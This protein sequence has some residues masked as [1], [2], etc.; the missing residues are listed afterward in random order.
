MGGALIAADFA[1]ALLHPDAARPLGLTD[2]MGRAAVRRFDV[3]RNNVTLGLIRVLEAGFPAVR[4]LV[5]EA[6]FAAMAGEFA[7]AHP[8]KTR[9]MMLSGDEFAGFI[10]QFPPAA[11]LGYLPCVARL[12]QALRLSYH[13]GDAAAMDPAILA[14]L[15]AQSLMQARFTCA[16]ALRLIT[17]PWPV[18]SIWR[19]SLHGGPAP[20]MARQEVIITRPAFD[21]V[22]QLLPMGAAQVIAQLQS[23]ARLGDALAG[24]GDDFDLGQTLSLLLA[25]GAFTKVDCDAE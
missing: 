12:E 7:R 6:F 16:P 24:T 18:L 15:P 21:P 20:I 5:G 9:M 14:A 10:A 2:A 8:P 3:Y 25:G 11:S 22:A 23:G 1:A 19:A 4:A 17:S 13:A